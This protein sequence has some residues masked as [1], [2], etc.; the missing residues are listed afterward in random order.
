MIINSTIFTLI[1]V[2]IGLYYLFL[3]LISFQYKRPLNSG[4][5]DYFYFILI[6]AKNEEKVI[7]RTIENFLKLEN[8][9]FRII[10]LNDK[11]IDR[12]RE[13]VFSYLNKDNRLVLLDRISFND[14]SGKGTVLNFGL[15]QIL[16]SLRHNFLESLNLDENFYEKYNYN[17]I[18]I[19]VF[20][21]DAIPHQ[22][23]FNR[24][25]DY[26]KNFDIDAV[27]TMIRIYNRDNNLLSKMQDI[28][29]LGFSQIIQKGRSILGSVGMGG[30]GQFTKLSSLLKLGDS[31]WGY[32]LTEDLELGLKFI[33]Y[34]MKLGYADDIITEQEGVENLL[35]LIRQ[36]SRWLQGHLSNWI[37][38]PKIIFSKSKFFTK[39][40][41]I[42]Y[43]TFVSTIFIVF[44]SIFLSI[45]G[46]F[47]VIYVK[48]YILNYFYSI[49]T[50]VGFLVLILFSFIFIPIFLTGI[51]GFYKINLLK[52]YIL[53]LIFAFY[54]YIWLPSFLLAIIKLIFNIKKWVKTERYAIE[55][56]HN[57]NI[58]KSY[59]NDRRAYPRIYL[60]FITKIDNK[61]IMV[62]DYSNGGLGILTKPD[63]FTDNNINI[64]IHELNIYR[65]GQIVYKYTIN[66]NLVRLGIKF[67]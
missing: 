34:G 4:Q 27:Q 53:I 40:D 54:T 60:N 62:L 48:N 46:F 55:E 36:R 1:L 32:T 65:K 59:E 43:L 39:L 44:L 2:F 38:I 31:P 11:S 3:Y 64:S 51:N 8:Q 37:Y 21:A 29:F 26:F 52:K 19:G 63:S 50:I 15:S 61:P 57:L 13:I 12:T 10:I 20:D 66:N 49:N 18:I 7:K 56:I 24:I 16:F 35:S 17:N 41:S 42:F 25:S 58:I 45:F 9:N 30:N 33:S 67:I 6:P 5:D 22:N 14:K 23:I 47:K 28:E